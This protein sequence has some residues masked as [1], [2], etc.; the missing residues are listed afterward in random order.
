M[1]T[2]T[3]GNKKKNNTVSSSSNNVPSWIPPPVVPVS[4]HVEES[5]MH[6]LGWIAAC[7]LVA[8]LLP[9]S[10]VVLTRMYN[11]EIKTEALNIETKQT[12]RQI[13]KLKQEL[14]QKEKQ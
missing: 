14:E 7:V 5:G 4:E 1:A 10:G 8:I 2:K 11:T 13:E 3:T 12:L 9:L 6:Y